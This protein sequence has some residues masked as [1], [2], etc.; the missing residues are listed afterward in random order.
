MR[1]SRTVTVLAAAGLL[2]AAVTGAAGRATASA[3]APGVC[4][5][6][7]KLVTTPALPQG[8]TSAYMTT[9]PAV[10]SA[11]NVWFPAWLAVDSPVAQNEPWVLHWNGHT[12]Q[13]AGV[14]P[15]TPDLIGRDTDTSFGG[16]F[17]SAD[18]WVL[19]TSTNGGLE[20]AQYAAHWYA[21]RWTITP[22]AVSPDPTAYENHLNAV[23]A[24]A[25][26]N[27]WGVGVFTLSGY[28]NFGSLIEHWDG[29]QWSIV[30]NPASS[31]GG[32]LTS[33][34]TLSPTN[35][36]AAGYQDNVSG[37]QVPLIEHWDG[38]SWSTVSTPAGPSP[39]G[40]LAI[41]ADSPDDIWAVGYQQEP[42]GPTPNAVTAFAEY[43]NGTAWSVVTGLPDTGNSEVQSVY[44]ASPSDVWAPV[45]TIRPND[46]E[47]TQDFEHW[48]GT[49]WTLVPVPG[50]QEYN[51]DYE[52]T[53]GGSGPDDVWASGY[54]IYD[55]G[56]AATLPVI[57]HLSCG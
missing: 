36:W 17:D 27:A 11:R 49:R 22:L 31:A 10:V 13:Q 45:L 46:N 53:I 56:N 44:A 18:G 20:D 37:A 4:T 32:E 6:T 39:S 52:Y 5:P 25:P 29:T 40:F 33:I 42:N 55:A 54:E 3:S 8:Y 12:L 26:D 57:A 34:S 14:I 19:G 15:Q 2:A 24:L 38:S 9:G 7:W 23:A 47:G 30:P 21:G 28:T 50:P 35:I 1:I 16:S 48:N 43:W 51:L 41:S